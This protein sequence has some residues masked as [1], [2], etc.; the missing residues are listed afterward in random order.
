MA[1]GIG[2]R[3][4]PAAYRSTIEAVTIPADEGPGRR[5]QTL[6]LVV[7]DTDAFGA[8][9][10]YQPGAPETEQHLAIVEEVPIMLEISAF[11]GL[12]PAAATGLWNDARDAQ[13]L[14]WESDPDIN[15]KI[16]AAWGGHLSPLVV[17]GG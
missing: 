6:Q 13:I 9:N 16:Q 5:V 1:I 12:D 14:A 4:R 2:I 15:A 8:E 17:W 10:P 7:Y 3:W 11:T